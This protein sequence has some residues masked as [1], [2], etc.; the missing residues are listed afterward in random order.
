MKVGISMIFERIN[1][2]TPNPGA[3]ARECE[4][5][6]LESVWVGDHMLFH[7]N[8]KTPFPAGGPIPDH[9]AHFPEPFVTLA[10]A[11]ATTAKLRIGTS[12]LLVPEHEPLATA[13]R[14][15]TLDRFSGG[16]LILGVGAGWLREAAEPLGSDFSHRWTQAAE[17][18]A[19]MRELWS[20]PAASFHG[21]YVNFDDI[22]CNP[23]PARPSGPPILIG[24]TD[25]N[26]LKWVARW[27]DGYNPVCFVADKAA[28]FMRRKMAEL[29]EECA[30]VGRDAGKLDVTVMISLPDDR[31]RT[32][33]ILGEFGEIGVNR[34]VE[35]SAAEPLFTG[36]YRAKLDRLARIAL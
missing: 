3:F 15:A 14:I 12:V 31:S 19:A 2:S 16:R 25:K 22:V 17:H 7:A 6:G 23:K 34:V 33:D 11:A 24:S 26:A 13:K 30:K 10:M 4:D 32:R 5:I 35:V 8:P 18:V 36:D 28:S 27:G 21:K 1:E 29:N 9:Y 20:K